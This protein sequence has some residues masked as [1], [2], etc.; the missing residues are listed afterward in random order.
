M[1]KWN[2][3]KKGIAVILAGATFLSSM[4][5]AAENLFT[6]GTEVGAEQV[7]PAEETAAEI[8]MTAELPPAEEESVT[9]EEAPVVEEAPVMEEPPVAEE[10]EAAE[11]SAATEEP[12]IVEEAPVVE[13]PP[14]TEEP[15][16]V[17]EAPMLEEPPMEETPPAAEEPP[18]T[19][20][21]SAEAGDL[22]T[23]GTGDVSTG[24]V[25]AEEPGEGDVSIE[26]PGT[27]E[28]PNTDIPGEPGTGDVPTEEVPVPEKTYPVYTSPTLAELGN[29]ARNEAGAA[30]EVPETVIP[31]ESQAY[32][33]FFQS[34]YVQEENNSYVT[35]N[36][37][38]LLKYQ[39]EFYAD[40]DLDNPFD[41]VIRIPKTLLWQQSGEES[42]P[43]NPTAI[44][45]PRCEIAE[46]G[47][48]ID[49]PSAVTPFNYYE[50]TGADGVTYLV[51]YNYQAVQAGM[52]T[53]FQVGYGPVDVTAV[54]DGTAWSL[55]P[56]LQIQGGEAAAYPALEGMVDLPEPTPEE[57]T[58]TPTPELTPTAV[59]EPTATPEPAPTAIPEAPIELTPEITPEPTPALTPEVSP[60]GVPETVPTEAP[61]QTPAVSPEI[62]PTVTPEATPTATPE[63]TPTAIP[64]PTPTLLPEY[65]TYDSMSIAELASLDEETVGAATETPGEMAVSLLADQGAEQ[66]FTWS[67]DAYYV[68]QN[69]PY[70]V[71]KTQDFSLKYQ[72]EFHTDYNLTNPGDIEI[73]IPRKLLQERKEDRARKI[74]PADI[75]VPQ[76]GKN[77]DGTYIAVKSR[78]TPFNYYV[79]TGKDDEEYLVFYNYEE[80]RAGTNAAWQVLYK[81]VDVSRIKNGTTWEL[82]PQITVKKREDNPEQPGEPP[83]IAEETRETTPL[84]G[85]VNTTSVLNSVTKDVLNISGKSY[86]PGLYTKRQVE[87]VLGDSLPEPYATNFDDYVFVGWKVSVNVDVVQPV[88]LEFKDATTYE[89]DGEKK[90]GK[91]VGTDQGIFK[92]GTYVI[93]Y[94]TEEE[95]NDDKRYQDGIR[96]IQVVTAYPKAEVTSGIRV[97]NTFTVTMELF[98]DKT[99]QEKEDDASWTYKDYYFTW[100]GKVYQAWKGDADSYPGWLNVFN[101]VSET[102]NPE[103]EAEAEAYLDAFPFTVHTAVNGYGL[104]H[105]VNT[106]NEDGTV[107]PGKGTIG[108]RIPGS[109]YEVTT[110]DGFFKFDGYIPGNS[111]NGQK[112]V[113]SGHSLQAYSNTAGEAGELPLDADDFYIKNVS[114]RR[115]DRDYDV[116]EDEYINAPEFDEGDNPVDQDI[117]V[118]AAYEA[119]S[120]GAE[121]DWKEVCTI[122]WTKD[123]NYNSSSYAVPNGELMK[124]GKYPVA[125]RTYYKGISYDSNCYVSFDVQLK[126]KSPVIQEL[127]DKDENKE[128]AIT[129]WNTARNDFSYFDGQIK[130][131]WDSLYRSA[132]KRVSLI[133]ED[134]S[135]SKTASVSSDTINGR[136]LVDYN[137]TAWSGY[138]IYSREALNYL[139]AKG[140]DELLFEDLQDENGKKWI[141]YDLLPYG[142]TLDFTKSVTAGRITGLDGNYQKYPQSWDKTDVSV[143]VDPETDVI[144]DW[145]GTGRTMV[146]FHL[147]YTGEDPTVYSKGL[148]MEGWG[149][150]FRARYDWK[151]INL[152]EKDA[153]ISAFTP[154]DASLKLVGAQYG[155]G[156][157]P[158][159]QEYETDYSP[160]GEKNGGIREDWENPDPA[161]KNILYAKNWTTGD[162]A[163]ASTSTI[164]K[165][166]RADDDIL[167]DYGTTAVVDPS[168]PDNPESTD[169]TYTYDITVTSGGVGTKDIV[170]YDRLEY[171]VADRTEE[172]TMDFGENKTLDDVWQGAFVGLD[173]TELEE[174]GIDVKVYYS[175]KQNAARPRVKKIEGENQEFEDPDAAFESGDWILREEWNSED[176]VKAIAVDIRKRDSGEAYILPAMESIGFKIKMRAPQEVDAQKPYTYNNPAFYSCPDNNRSPEMVAGDS[177]RVE[178]AQEKKNLE[179]IKEFGNPQDV[180]EE[181]KDQEFVFTITYPAINEGEPNE[182]YPPFAYQVYTLFQETEDGT[183]TEVNDGQV[184]TT[185][186]EGKLTL[187]AG[188]KAVFKDVRGV[189][190]LIITEEESPFWKVDWT[191]SKESDPDAP[192]RVVSF[193]NTYRP[194]LYIQKKIQAVPED[195][196]EE[197]KEHTF[198]F[199]VKASY[200]DDDGKEVQQE[201][202]EGDIYW[203]VDAARTDG[204]IPNK[205]AEKKFNADGYLELKPGEIAAVF[206]DSPESSYTV[207]EHLDKSPDGENWLCEEPEKSG[208]ASIMG[209]KVE[210][211]NTYRWK[212][213]ILLKEITHQDK[214]DVAE[215]RK[216]LP[217]TFEVKEVVKGEDGTETEK[218]VTGKDW[219]LLNTDGSEPKDGERPDHVEKEEVV[220]GKLD[221]DGRFTCAMANRR[222]KIKGL[223]AGKTYVIYEVVYKTEDD[224]PPGITDDQKQKL[225]LYKPVNGGVTEVTMPIYS[226]GKD[227]TIVNDYQMR[228]LTVS[229]QV[230]LGEN[231]TDAQI[232]AAE[233]MYFSMT[234]SVNGELLKN[235]PY[236]LFENGQ[237]VESENPTQTNEYG[238]LSLKG[239][240]SAYFKDVGFLG[241][242]FEVKESWEPSSNGVG[243]NQ[244]YPPENKPFE[245][246]LTGDGGEASFI[247]GIGKNLAVVKEYIGGDDKGKEIAGKIPTDAAL[248]KK[249]AVEATFVFYDKNGDIIEPGI[250]GNR[251]NK[252][253]VIDLASG[254]ISTYDWPA[255]ERTLTLEPGKMYVFPEKIWKGASGFDVPLASYRITEEKTDYGYLYREETADGEKETWLHIQQK[256]QG[257]VTGTVKEN[258]LAKLVNEITVPEWTDGTLIEKRM[259][260]DAET[261]LPQEVPEGSVLTLRLERY[262]KDT[263]T[264]LPAAGISYLQG[265][266]LLYDG[267][268][269]DISADYQV[270]EG[271]YGVTGSDGTISCVKSGETFAYPVVYFPKDKV[272][273]NLYGDTL[274]GAG[275]PEGTFR[276][277]E[278]PGLSDP[279]WGYLTGY[280]TA[281]NLSYSMEE[282]NGTILYNRTG[283]S[284][285]DIEKAMETDSD[286]TFTMILKQVLSQSADPIEKPEHILKSQAVPGMPYIVYDRETHAEISR[287][288]TGKNGEIYLKAG[289][290][291]RLELSEDTKW[292]VEE[293]Q[294]VTTVL[295]KLEG[296]PADKMKPLSDNLMLINQP[297]ETVQVG[298]ITYDANGGTFGTAVDAPTVQKVSYYMENGTPTPL[299]T[300]VAEPTG[301]DD[302]K[303]DGWY[304]KPD[305]N[306]PFTL[307]EYNCKTDL[308]VYA[309]WKKPADVKY[310]VTLYGIEMD[311]YRN[312]DG[313]ISDKPA[314]LTFGPATGADYTKQGEGHD[315]SGNTE[316]GNVHRCLHKDSW[317]EIISWSEKDPWVYEE[318]LENRCTKSVELTLNDELKGSTI[319]MRE[320][321]GDGASILYFSINYRYRNWNKTNNNTGGWPASRMRAT[322][323]GADNL[324]DRSESIAGKDVLETSN[325]L[326]TCFPQELQEAIVA[327]AVKSDTDPNDYEN[328]IENKTNVTTYDKLWLF[329]VKELFQE[330]ATGYRRNEGEPY[331]TNWNAPTYKAIGYHEEGDKYSFWLRS[332]SYTHAGCVT[333]VIGQGYV[334]NAYAGEDDRGPSPGFCI[335]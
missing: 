133:G 34:F 69:D 287:S 33:W 217:F 131:S 24:D 329:S 81:N 173:T 278:V 324:T 47:S 49:I 8:S 151:D 313:N 174:A 60:S 63:P 183:W 68:G 80:I 67:F 86:G 292:T 328:S 285:V 307:T 150:S 53:A 304:K 260:I 264:W 6:D 93:E 185:D 35:K 282:K 284:P 274:N 219:L 196:K 9:A 227:A 36:Q 319:N 115:V 299:G 228:P 235:T 114:V 300:D 153:N 179:I 66:A 180:P 325:C 123:T 136:V 172:D 37:E 71:S 175:E 149:V 92:D 310:A 26:E 44:G 120:D 203:L 169:S 77:P 262:Q 43:V 326:L 76:G 294:S 104:T 200:K 232:E 244:I 189:D 41:V 112:P 318:C 201:F 158:G 273:L 127:L 160:F 84:T 249:F 181:L 156:E 103:A 46:D 198:V 142:M 220:S 222:V 210:I 255:D 259:A 188:E 4:P 154:E 38:F 40:C 10:P 117:H 2:K 95:A 170:I 22:F 283:G 98:D 191:D 148:W 265:D 271:S 177:V 163:V 100:S 296:T 14:A 218:P 162:V 90:P 215:V 176:T 83:V 312:A 322:L 187:H 295:E 17:E 102:D 130:T 7:A 139:R 19:E 247:N 20:D 226:T 291:A 240:Q 275:I 221:D 245:G 311:T 16:A 105:H 238:T 88:R 1:K 101:K 207:T 42:L 236:E 303:F 184:R 48:R 241:D 132:Q 3:W 110:T 276:L 261:H 124:D 135:A 250:K 129:V 109:Y 333:R 288:Q 223:E 61:E 146:K 305:G 51:F 70:H 334:S 59:P 39:I 50:E 267:S 308:T 277:V 97:D 286:E 166:V 225:E 233:N 246:I 58:A 297:G 301:V 30:T 23:D 266:R 45:V 197:V 298:T 237:K 209:S 306:E 82:T 122:P 85:V 167:N 195:K 332:A 108:E 251:T 155:N 309:K 257:A 164:K 75:A 111:Q 29:L 243:F 289:Q 320:M 214:E 118:F 182:E 18:V 323:N 25:P 65:P 21:T 128:K 216:D 165:L 317:K 168:D 125:I 212:E 229:K 330:G 224:Y 206:L 32:N 211:I 316:K 91:L 293:Q 314:G 204:G 199:E 178:L 15:P 99:R 290:Y 31:A 253:K 74:F 72:M 190:D 152:L 87:R 335:R 113:E 315:P 279:G 331:G 186:K 321:T 205:L 192:A 121:P 171:A 107:E 230:L 145:K 27:G 234:V 281:G 239:G 134:A 5:A 208:E 138:N 12:P 159:S 270:T 64:E 28:V 256:P 143:Y 268:S 137:L 161:V 258:P 126:R 194:V 55:T 157:I 252:I 302:M 269:Y 147:T 78:V 263:K 231:P 202:K 327:K 56:T 242:T 213:L 79:E 89:K 248:Q 272:Y 73:R 254:E 57:P 144:D 119:P 193:T 140:A 141:F 106:K 62:T 116:W 96:D 94:Y 11:E 280:G 13:T 54:A 52:G